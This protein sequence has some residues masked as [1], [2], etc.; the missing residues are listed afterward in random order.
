[1]GYASDVV[2]MATAACMIRFDKVDLD[3]LMQSCKH[4]SLA[5]SNLFALA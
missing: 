1:M 5:V 3:R 2:H 4:L